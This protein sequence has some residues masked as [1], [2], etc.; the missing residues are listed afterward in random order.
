M[1][2]HKVRKRDE[3]DIPSGKKLELA[4]VEVA[5]DGTERDVHV[6]WVSYSTW[7]LTDGEL[8]RRMNEWGKSRLEDVKDKRPETV[9]PDDVALED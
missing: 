1:S 2:E 5:D 9:N 4:L 6:E 3:K 8:E 7:Q